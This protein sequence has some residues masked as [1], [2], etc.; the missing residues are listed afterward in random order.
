MSYH[1]HEKLYKIMIKYVGRAEQ[2]RNVQT[3][4]N[5]ITLNIHL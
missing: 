2:N 3:I 4:K 5:I 1:T